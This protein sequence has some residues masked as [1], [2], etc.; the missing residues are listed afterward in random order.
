MGVSPARVGVSAAEDGP[1]QAPGGGLCLVV[2][3]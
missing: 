2:N 3:G 1:G